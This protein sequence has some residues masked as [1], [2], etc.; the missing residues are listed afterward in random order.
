MHVSNIGVVIMGVGGGLLFLFFF[1]LNEKRIFHSPIKSIQNAF[2]V[3]FCLFIF[4]TNEK[5][6]HN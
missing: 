1:N 2:P 6:V 4:N 3:D 5:I